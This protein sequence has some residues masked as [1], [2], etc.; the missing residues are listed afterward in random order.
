MSRELKWRFPLPRTHTGILQGRQVL[1][2]S[3]QHVCWRLRRKVTE[4][5]I[6]VAL[7]DEDRT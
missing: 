5:D 4:R 1:P 2:W 3:H 7:S 6:E